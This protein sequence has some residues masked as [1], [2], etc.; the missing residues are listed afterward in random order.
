MPAGP[1]GWRVEG[2]AAVARDARADAAHDGRDDA[3]ARDDGLTFGER[4]EFIEE[5]TARAFDRL[6]DGVLVDGIDDAHD[7]LRHALREHVLIELAGALRDEADADAELTPFREKLFEDIGRDDRLTG[8]REAMR[9]FKERED[10]I[11]KIVVA[12]RNRL[13]THGGDARLVDAP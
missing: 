13:V 11:G 7:D 2:L 5:L 12:A 1:L 8:G 4:R 6:G 9:L 3:D 10:G